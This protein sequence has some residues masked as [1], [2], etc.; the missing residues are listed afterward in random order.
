[1]IWFASKAPLA[2]AG[3][4][5]GWGNGYIAVPPSHFLW[6]M[7]Y[8]KINELVDVHYGLTFADIIDEGSTT[9]KQ[10]APIGWWVF[11]YDTAHYDDSL[12]KWPKEA[13]EAE[14]KKLLTQIFELDMGDLF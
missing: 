8:D 2:L 11:G 6:G 3:I 10:Y 12:E 13:V 4:K 9:F 1:M 14:T 5:L 7:E